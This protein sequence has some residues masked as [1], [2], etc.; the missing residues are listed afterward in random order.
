MIMSEDYP[1]KEL[2]KI[3][4]HELRGELNYLEKKEFLKE[5]IDTRVILNLH[6]KYL[7]RKKIVTLA[8]LSYS[9]YLA[10]L[11]LIFLVNS[12]SPVLAVLITLAIIL[13]PITAWS[14]FSKS[15]LGY[16]KLDLVL[17]I[18]TKFYVRKK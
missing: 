1:I 15:V 18:M 2:R 8:V 17:R 5:S 4:H 7:N 9:I 10:V 11:L 13:I 16:Q 12:D 6:E 3:L 14:L